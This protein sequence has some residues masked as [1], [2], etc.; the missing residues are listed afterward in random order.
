MKEPVKCT[1]CGKPYRADKLKRCPSCA[2]GEVKFSPITKPNFSEPS[3]VTAFASA[4]PRVKS[5]SSNASRIAIES[6]KIVNAYG[7][8]IQVLGVIF[9]ILVIIGGLVLA[10]S[11]GAI[12][13]LAGILIG[14]LDIAIFAV[15]GALF[16]MISNYVIAQLEN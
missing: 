6:A 11:N 3:T 5:S 12:Y 1:N 8:V 15:Q 13:A 14:S 16:R 9:G 10:H 2:A 4:P 7:T